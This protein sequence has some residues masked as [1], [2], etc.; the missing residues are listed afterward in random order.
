MPDPDDWDG[1]I[2]GD[3]LYQQ[4]A[5]KALP[6]LVRQAEAAQTI[7]YSDLADE[8]AMPNPRNLDYPLGAIGK[9]LLSLGAEWG[10]AIP[11]I[12]CVVINKADGFPGKGIG[13]FINEENFKA[14]SRARK[15]EVIHAK[16]QDIF[17]YPRW[18]E[19]LEALHLP[20]VPQNYTE[21]NRRAAALGGGG[22][23]DDHK[24]LK[25]YVASTPALLDLPLG[26]P[27]GE[28]EYPLPSGD[29]LDVSFRHRNEWVAAEVKS[30]RSSDD[31]IMRGIYQCVKYLAVM[32]AVQITESKER[33]ARVVLVL[34]GPLPKS[35]AALK[36]QLGVEVKDRVQVP[37]RST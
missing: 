7:T 33:S 6:L 26:T 37:P 4:R 15:R 19:V 34:E 11:P 2:D 20:Y 9:R 27:I 18:R 29:S 31:D 17:A 12:Q 24:V 13:W 28:Q 23:S 8:L 21:A 10:E 25:T 30:A 35:L 22:E 3:Q 5:R 36:N 14:L 1:S 32:R 16:L